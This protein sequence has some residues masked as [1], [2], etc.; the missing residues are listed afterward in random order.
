MLTIL[1]SSQTGMQ[2]RQILDRKPPT[3][4]SILSSST[5]FSALRRATSGLDS[6]SAITASI[7]RPLTPPD[8]LILST[9]IC[10]P[11]S[12]VLPP[13]A[14]APD[15]GCNEPT[16][17]GAAAPNAARHGAGTRMVA[18]R[19]P[20]PQPTTVRRVT[21]PLYQRSRPHSSPFHFSVIASTPSTFDFLP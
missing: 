10:R 20:P 19:T 14:P 7:G 1:A 15:S 5:S 11:T 18:P 8:A 6:S 17:K 4:T 13:A 16:L 12:A 2:A 9:A 3:W 21:L